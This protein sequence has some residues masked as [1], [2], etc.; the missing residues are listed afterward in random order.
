MAMELPAREIR[1]FQDDGESSRQS[2]SPVADTSGLLPQQYPGADLFNLTFVGVHLSS[3]P[4]L[5]F[6]RGVIHIEPELR[7]PERPDE[8]QL[9]D[10]RVCHDFKRKGGKGC[11]RMPDVRFPLVPHEFLMGGISRGDGR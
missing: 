7:I 5:P 11:Y 2:V 8:A 10:K 3:R 6:F 1:R 4:T 9:P